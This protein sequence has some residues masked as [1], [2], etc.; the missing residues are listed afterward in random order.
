MIQSFRSRR[1]KRLWVDND[2]TTIDPNHVDKIWLQ[3]DTLNRATH[4]N[5]MKVSGWKL[6]RAPS[7]RGEGPRWKVD[8]NGPWRIT[9]GWGKDG[10]IDVNYENYH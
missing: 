1:L 3:L 2:A 5:A 7:K 10:P 4:R 9:F 8:V 6:H